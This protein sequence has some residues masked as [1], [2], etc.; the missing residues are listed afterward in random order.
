MFF[1]FHYSITVPK[2]L[3]LEQVLVWP[4]FL[5]MDRIAASRGANTNKWTF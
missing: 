5:Q 1:I 2:K 3:D 4:Y